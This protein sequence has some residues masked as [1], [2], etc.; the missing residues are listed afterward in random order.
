[1]K[2]HYDKCNQCAT[3]AQEP[4]QVPSTSTKSTA[5]TVKATVKR[6]APASDDASQKKRVLG[7][8]VFETSSKQ[9]ESI[10]TPGYVPPSRKGVADRY[11]PPIYEKGGKF[12][13]GLTK[14]V[15]PAEWLRSHKGMVQEE[16]LIVVKLLFSASSGAK[17][18]YEPRLNRSPYH[19]T[20]VIQLVTGQIP[21]SFQCTE[22][23]PD[24]GDDT[25]LKLLIRQDQSKQQ[26]PIAFSSQCTERH[27]DLGD[28]THL[29]LL[30][31]QDQS[32]QQEPIAF[33]SQCTERHP[34]LGDD[35]HLKLLIRQDQSK[36]QEPIAF[37]SQCTERHP[38]LGDDTHL[39]LLIRQD[40]SKQQ[41]PIAFSS[42]CTEPH[43]DL[44]DD[45]HLKLLIR[46]DQPK[47]QDDLQLH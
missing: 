15:S 12:A 3:Q 45:T 20:T 37:S 10:S 7:S 21:V 40:Q 17:V 36:Q 11:L 8:F 4:T 34:D 5:T 2:V 9:K 39:K 14:A 22:P 38:D 41:E 26:E 28:D 29:K 46:Q 32:K 13:D 43:P 33:S 42:Q 18:G 1:M 47:Q 16:K 30:I 23:H 24:L 25:H 27:P 6:S 31:R 35:T 44:G 19:S